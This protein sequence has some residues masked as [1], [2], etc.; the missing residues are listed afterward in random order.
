MCS[1]YYL[2]IFPNIPVV[3]PKYIRLIGNQGIQKEQKDVLGLGERN[4]I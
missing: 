1:I 2:Y 4:A 3:K